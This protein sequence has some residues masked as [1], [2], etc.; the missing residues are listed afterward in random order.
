MKKNNQLIALFV[1]IPMLLFTLFITLMSQKDTTHYD[2]AKTVICNYFDYRNNKDIN[3]LSSLLVNQ[4]IPNSLESEINDTQKISL[5]SITEEKNDSIKK[6]YLR[7]DIQSS[8]KNVK[9]FKVSY[10]I[11]YKS[12]E[13]SYKDGIYNSW[14]FLIRENE[15]SN[16]LIDIFDA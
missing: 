11:Q 16:W 12:K 14:Y 10:E 15:N 1:F 3:S 8:T 13:L 6:A 4:D 2:E 5:I 7:N 9:V